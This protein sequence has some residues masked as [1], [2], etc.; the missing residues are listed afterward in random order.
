ML[1]TGHHEEY[2][3][4]EIKECMLSTGHHEEYSTVEMNNNKQKT[5]KI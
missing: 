1:S 4:V 5:I 3:T 2:S